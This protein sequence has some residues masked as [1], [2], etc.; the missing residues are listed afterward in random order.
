MKI[1]YDDDAHCETYACGVCGYTYN[2]YYDSDKR[3]ANTE[4]PFI[5]LEE[6]LLHTVSR[7]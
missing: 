1:S 7:S 5:K 4:E 3:V 6:P 2:Y